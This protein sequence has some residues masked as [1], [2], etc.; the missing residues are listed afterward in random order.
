MP[1]QLLLSVVMTLLFTF[2]LCEIFPARR[3]VPP[4]VLAAGSCCLELGTAPAD[5]PG[6]PC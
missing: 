1:R 2:L 5:G 6:R 3:P 4:P